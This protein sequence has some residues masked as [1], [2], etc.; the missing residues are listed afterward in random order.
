[1]LQL[2]TVRPAYAPRPPR[3]AGIVFI[4]LLH[5]A[6]IYALLTALDVVPKPPILSPLIVTNIASKTVDPP[7]TKPEEPIMEKVPLPVP[8]PPIID[9]ILDPVPSETAILVPRPP[10]VIQPTP[11]PPVAITPASPVAGTHTIPEYPIL[12]RRLAEEG[13]V[14]L[15]IIINADGVVREATVK[16]SSGF[17]RLDEAAVDWVKRNWRYRPAMRGVM[18]IDSMTGVI[19]QFKL[20][21]AGR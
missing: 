11:I 6:A 17:R 14:R 4:A 12:S 15:S 13:A 2:A 7:P 20:T 8:V 18:P 10:P 1:M 19:L 21:E 16:Q 9:I 5:A 3:T